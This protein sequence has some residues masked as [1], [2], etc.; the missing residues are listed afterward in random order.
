MHETATRLEARLQHAESQGR[1][2]FRQLER[3]STDVRRALATANQ[4]EAE[5]RAQLE[6][7][8]FQ[9][10]HNRADNNAPATEPQDKLVEAVGE[11]PPPL[12]SEPQA[13]DPGI[14]TPAQAHEPA[15]TAAADRSPLPPPIVGGDQDQSPVEPTPVDLPRPE[16]LSEESPEARIHRL[17]CSLLAAHA[18]GP[19]HHL[20]PFLSRL[21]R[22]LGMSR[23]EA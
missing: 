13:N 17:R 7:L 11:D 12:P 16:P 5:L 18:A 20:R 14:A 4:H 19:G 23:P 22:L 3:E 9:V 21:G 6:R 15:A 2:A 1:A 10:D 8:Q